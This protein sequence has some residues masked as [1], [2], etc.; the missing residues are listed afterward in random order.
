MLL[1]ALRNQ[2]PGPVGRLM[3]IGAISPDTAVRPSTAKI[4]RS[5]ELN[6]PVR[7]GLVVMLPDGRCWVDVPKV[8]RRRWMIAIIAAVIVAVLAELLWLFLRW[9]N[10]F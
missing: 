1:L 8:K 10:V 7:S 9:A 4:A 6:G 5:Y 3:K 2:P